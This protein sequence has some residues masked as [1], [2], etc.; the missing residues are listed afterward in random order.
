MKRKEKKRKEKKRKEKKKGRDGEVEDEWYGA[1][2]KHKKTTAPITWV[3]KPNSLC[4][5]DISKLGTE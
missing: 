2:K 3:E 1:W 5:L 4:I